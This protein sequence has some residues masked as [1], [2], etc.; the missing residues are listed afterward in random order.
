MT[1]METKIMRRPETFLTLLNFFLSSLVLGIN[2]FL[3]KKKKSEPEFLELRVNSGH[4][5]QARA[6]FRFSKF[7]ALALRALRDSLSSILSNTV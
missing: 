2:K 6:L 4:H 5:D 3:M 1:D 7:A